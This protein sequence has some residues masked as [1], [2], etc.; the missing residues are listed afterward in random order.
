[1]ASSVFDVSTVDSGY[2]TNVT[3]SANGSIGV[4][5]VS[6][7][8]VG[9]GT[10]NPNSDLHVSGT[11][12]VIPS[13][14]T[15]GTMPA[16]REGTIRY[17]PGGST[18]PRLFYR[19][20]SNWFRFQS[21]ANATVYSEVIMSVNFSGSSVSVTGLNIYQYVT[22]NLFDV[23]LSGQ[24]EIRLSFWAGGSQITGVWNYGHHMFDSTGNKGSSA[25]NTSAVRINGLFFNSPDP[26][27][28]QMYR[29]WFRNRNVNGKHD[30]NPHGYWT[31]T[32]K[33]LSD[34][35]WFATSG[36]FYGATTS[37]IDE[38]RIGPFSQTMSGYI[39]VIGH[40]W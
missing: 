18:L 9:I 4:A 35:Y 37:T 26:N 25:Q 36:A 8:G 11:D 7:K 22:I 28:P 12:A 38:I 39:H 2:A 40:R 10:T 21:N 30:R 27:N 6:A 14:G 20:G 29:I 24:D 16:S 23:T 5:V 1:M 17:V 19:T 15:S 34:S 32:G 33:S 3:I 13:S 31:G